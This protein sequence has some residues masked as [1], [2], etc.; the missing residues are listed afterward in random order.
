MLELTRSRV[1]SLI[2]ALGASS[3][4]SAAFA[5]IKLNAYSSPDNRCSGNPVVTTITRSGV[6]GSKGCT[7]ISTQ[8][9]ASVAITGA[10]DIS[11][12]VS[13]CNLWL[14]SDAACNNAVEGI[15]AI[16]ALTWPQG[17][18]APGKNIVAATLDCK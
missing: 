18:I 5:S 10:S 4:A 17:C 15:G 1:Q 14:Y 6:L 12:G 3:L 13:S 11:D 7:A 9:V 16:T 8:A 2:L